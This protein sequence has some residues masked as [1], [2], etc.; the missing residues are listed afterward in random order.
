MNVAWKF[1][2]VLA[3]LM[4]MSALYLEILDIQSRPSAA[5]MQQEVTA[6]LA[7]REK[8][9]VELLAP[10]I[11]QIRLDADLPVQPMQSLEDLM[12]GLAEPVESVNG[13]KVSAAQPARKPG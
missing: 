2:A 5:A 13:G 12:H 10:K 11:N 1:I 6:Q 7:Q 9:L 4:S 8:V 3:L